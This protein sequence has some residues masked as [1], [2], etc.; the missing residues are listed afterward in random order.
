VHNHR[1]RNLHY[2]PSLAYRNNRER[3]AALETQLASR[4]YAPAEDLLP[5][6]RRFYVFEAPLP[7]TSVIEDSLLAEN[8]FVRFLLD[9]TWHM[10]DDSGNWI[11][12]GKALLF[13]AN[14][15][16][17]P[18]QVKGPFKF[19]GFAIRPSAWRSLIASPATEFVD[20]LLPL[21]IA[22]GP[23]A[24][25]IQK[26][27]GAA[28]NDEAIVEAMSSGIREQLKLIGRNK[29]DEKIARLEQIARLDSTAKI[30]NVAA[31]LGLSVRQLERR[32][33][34]AWG[35]SPK[36]VMRRSRFL[37]MAEAMRGMS[38]PG[39]EMLA[40]LRYFDQSHINREVRH[41]VGMTPGKFAKAVTPLFDAGLKL[42]VEG[43][44][45]S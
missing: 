17:M 27:I 31:E 10:R 18:V 14:A 35:I 19:A 2:L 43:K 37:D 24:D 44:A 40:T 38:A 6:V 33:L 22:W 13:G 5:F 41:F 11:N 21:S 7:K 32:S 42:R 28:S 16:A 45:I 36:T 9:G 34:T 12:P 15:K 3:E 30:E 25:K 1:A 26:Q 23:I 8:A 4:N 29:V 20:K 39:G